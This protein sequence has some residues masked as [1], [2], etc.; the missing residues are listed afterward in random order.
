MDATE[1]LAKRWEKLQLSTEESS[2]FHVKQEV[3]Q[4]FEGLGKQC[5]MAKAMVDKNVNS[6][7][8]RVTMS[9]IWRLE[10]WVRFKELGDQSF[11]IEFQKMMDKEKVLGGRTWFFDRCL[12][13]IQEVDETQSINALQFRYEP[14]WV[15]LHNLPLVT[16][17]ETF[18]EEFAAS[19]GPVIRVEAGSDGRAWG[20]CLRVR[21]AVDLHKPLMRGKWLGVD[22]KQHWISFK[23]ERLQN[24][25]FQCDTLSHK[26]RTCVRSRVDQQSDDLNLLQFG[27]GYELNP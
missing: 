17:T 15:Q 5:I 3:H 21:V 8:F 18:G 1:D 2:C 7:A 26:G 20:R 22:G 27:L 12:L 9:Q 11:L 4:G 13:A 24:F 6:E 10:G 23:Y 14:F 19:I 25:C 16:V